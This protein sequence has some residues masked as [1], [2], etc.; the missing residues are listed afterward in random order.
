VLLAYSPSLSDKSGFLIIL[1]IVVACIEPA[2]LAILDVGIV[3]RVAVAKVYTDGG[4][5][6][7]LTV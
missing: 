7:A 2:N 6:A 5:M 1:L 3:M 4:T